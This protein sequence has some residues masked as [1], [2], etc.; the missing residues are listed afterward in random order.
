MIGR[1]DIVTTRGDREM[2]DT[3]D[4]TPAPIDA[5]IAAEGEDEQARRDNAI[6]SV[7]EGTST[8]IDVVGAVTEGLGAVVDGVAGVIGGLFEG[9]S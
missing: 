9:L 8:G 6:A 2:S 3:N 5:A 4:P 1:H 7:I